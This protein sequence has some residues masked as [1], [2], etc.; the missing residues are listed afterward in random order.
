[1]VTAAGTKTFFHQDK[2]DSVVAMSDVN[3]N[4]T[5]G[6]YTYDSYGNG[7][8]TTGVPFKYTGQ[9]LD[10]ETGL[11]YYRARYYSSAL[12]RF[13]QVDPIGYKDDIAWYDYTGDDPTDK[14]DPTG[15]DDSP[16]SMALNNANLQKFAHDHP[17]E[18]MKAQEK[19]LKIIGNVGLVVMTIPSG[20]EGAEAEGGFFVAN[21]ARV[22]WSGG[23]EAMKAARAFAE[24]TGGRTLEM[25]GAGKFLSWIT[26]TFG[27]RKVTDA[28]WRWASRRWASGIKEGV[29]EV[30]VFLGKD[31]K[32]TSNWSTI[33]KDVLEKK[34]VKFNEHKL[35]CRPLTD[36]EGY[37]CTY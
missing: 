31:V 7:A 24:A 26:K 22:F 17:A 13:L 12:G 6:P 4:L 36:A 14:N 19:A 10:P 32:P 1:M 20:G 18:A 37:S 27:R 15:K 33:E 28:L 23:Q 9:R 35:N 8:P 21:N 34:G 16:Y 25:T 11:Y 2:T 30:D 3:G 5:E 29:G